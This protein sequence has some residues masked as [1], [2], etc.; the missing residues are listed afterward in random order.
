M[1][2]A[3]DDQKFKWCKEETEKNAQAQKMK[4]DEVTKDTNE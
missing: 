3:S 1:E 4:Q 2:Q